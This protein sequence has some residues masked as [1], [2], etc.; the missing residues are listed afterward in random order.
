MRPEK[1]AIRRVNE[2]TI[3]VTMPNTQFDTDAQVRRLA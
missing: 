2:A 1:I 3:I